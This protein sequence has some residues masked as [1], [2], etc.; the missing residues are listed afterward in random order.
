[1]DSGGGNGRDG[2]FLPEEK[3]GVGQNT[4]RNGKPPEEEAPRVLGDDPWKIS[5]GSGTG[6]HR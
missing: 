4:Q 3:P 6:E 2:K 1:M 5:T